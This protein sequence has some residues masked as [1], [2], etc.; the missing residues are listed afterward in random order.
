MLCI[1]FKLFKRLIYNRIQNN[2]KKLLLLEQTG[3]RHGRGTVELVA[4]MT[5]GIE[6][7]FDK[8]KKVGT[9]FV[10]LSLA[11]YTIWHRG[12]TLNFL[13]TIPNKNIVKIIVEMIS[14][15]LLVLQVHL[16]YKRSRKRRLTTGVPQGSVLAPMLFNLYMADIPLTN[17]KIL[18]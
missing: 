18:I 9:V 17:C 4:L 16:G 15:R 6:H 10:D 2:I 8:K 11:Y 5:N 7:F 14:Q 1:P 12:L 3:F 13:K